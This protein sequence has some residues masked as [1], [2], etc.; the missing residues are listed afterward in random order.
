ML[1]WLQQK[2][3]KPWVSNMEVQYNV[4]E[5]KEGM[6]FINSLEAN[7]VEPK[8]SQR[9]A[10]GVENGLTNQNGWMVIMQ[11]FLSMSLELK[12]ILHQ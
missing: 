3:G 8:V 6:E 9:Q 2:Y 7:H 4:N 1:L 11:E 5:V 12:I 10:D